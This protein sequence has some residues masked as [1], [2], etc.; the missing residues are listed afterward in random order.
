MRGEVENRT[1]R[2]A[3]KCPGGYK[4]QTLGIFEEVNKSNQSKRSNCS[5]GNRN[6]T[7][8][9]D[10]LGCLKELTR[11]T[12][13]KEFERLKELTGLLCLKEFER[14]KELTGLTCLKEFKGVIE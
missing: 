4:S 13:L 9:T 6:E 3:R 14:L 11:L 12:C 1:N 10:A 8:R 7:S 2:N 5:G